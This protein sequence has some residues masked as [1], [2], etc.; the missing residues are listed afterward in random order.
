M[1]VSWRVNRFI[2]LPAGGYAG[3]KQDTMS[4]RTVRAEDDQGSY[5]GWSNYETWVIR[6]WAAQDN[7]AHEL[8]KLTRV[9]VSTKKVLTVKQK[10]RAAFLLQDRLVSHCHAQADE[11]LGETR[12]ASVFLDILNHSLQRARWSEI[13]QSLLED[14][15]AEERDGWIQTTGKRAED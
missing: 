5:G 7:E 3:R 13:A 1:I 12:R 8:A 2:T 15:Y 10:N 6:L 14:V 11:W 4:F 9:E